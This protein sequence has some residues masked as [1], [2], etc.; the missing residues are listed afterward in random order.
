[1]KLGKRPLLFKCTISCSFLSRTKL[2]WLEL[3]QHSVL[4]SP[5]S[6]LPDG[7]DHCPVSMDSP[8]SMTEWRE[9]ASEHSFLLGKEKRTSFI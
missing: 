6:H 7:I 9:S 3:L 5:G 2:C 1:M 4:G 8:T